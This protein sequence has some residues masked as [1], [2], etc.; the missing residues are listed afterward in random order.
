MISQALWKTKEKKADPESAV[1]A[2]ADARLPHLRC[3][4]AL[5]G[6]YN[7]TIDWTL[8]SVSIGGEIIYSRFQQHL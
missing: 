1:D 3:A 8:A 5:L 2:G 4:L 6:Q 7:C